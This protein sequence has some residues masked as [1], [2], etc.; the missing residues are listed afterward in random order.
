MDKTRV[1]IAKLDGV[2]GEMIAAVKRNAGSPVTSFQLKLIN[3]VLAQ[4]NALLKDDL[5]FDGFSQFDMDDLPTAGD[6]SMVIAQY[7]E[8]FEKVRCENIAAYGNSRW[9]WKDGAGTF[10]VA[11]RARK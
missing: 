11:P 7:V 3:G 8:V 1:V 10:T 6:V 2:H 9:H 5:P 4:A